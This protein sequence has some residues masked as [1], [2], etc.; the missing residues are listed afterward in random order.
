MSPDQRLAEIAGFI[1][2]L[3][4]IHP[5]RIGEIGTHRGGT[6]FLLGH[7][8]PSVELV[9]GIDLH[10]LNAF[11]LRFYR[12]E[13]VRQCLV[14]GGSTDP[15]TLARVRQALGG[16]LLD[17][18]FIDG[19]HS[20]EGVTSDFLTYRA[21]VRPG[22]LIAFHD[23]V[24]DAKSRGDRPTGAYAGDVPELWSRMKTAYDHREF[25]KDRGQ[26]GMGIGVITYSPDIPVPDLTP[27]A[28]SDGVPVELS[29]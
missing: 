23:I 7:A 14:N 28:A 4:T 1:S 6:T 29:A 11:Q 21:L 17:V 19:D 16:Q 26:D 22:G 25:V 15:R 12:S 10:V 20:W 5:H 18:L 27:P 13:S 9:I 8:L 3:D 2:H 24:P